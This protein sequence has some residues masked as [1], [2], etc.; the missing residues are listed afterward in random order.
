MKVGSSPYRDLITS[1]AQCGGEKEGL[2]PTDC[3]ENADLAAACPQP[4]ASS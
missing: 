4:G 3:W 2:T 1:S